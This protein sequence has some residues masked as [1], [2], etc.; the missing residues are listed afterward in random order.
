M[1]N[2]PNNLVPFNPALRQAQGEEG[3]GGGLPPGDSGGGDSEDLRLAKL[4]QNDLGV[5]DRLIARFGDDLTVTHEMGWGSWDGTRYYFENGE[6]IARRRAHDVAR[7]M[8]EKEYFAFKSQNDPYGL[9]PEEWEKVV[10]AFYRFANGAANAGKTDA[11]LKQGEP[12]L[13]KPL[14][15]FDEQL[16]QAPNMAQLTHTVI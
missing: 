10:K 9:G 6:D 11:I 2:T 16:N 7:L 15:A 12:Y 3:G 14:N 8:R 1:S 13:R 4:P 5:A